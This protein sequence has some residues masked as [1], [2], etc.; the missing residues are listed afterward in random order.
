[1][2]RISPVLCLGLRDLKDYVRAIKYGETLFV[3]PPYDNKIKWKESD[4]NDEVI[5]YREDNRI[6]N[7]NDNQK[8]VIVVDKARTIDTSYQCW[9]MYF[10]SITISNDDFFSNLRRLFDKKYDYTKVVDDMKIGNVKIENQENYLT[11]RIMIISIIIIVFI[12]GY[13]LGNSN[14]NRENR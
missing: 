1:M 10:T 4:V 7:Q 14:K 9:P 8:D 5:I 11:N 12:A 6:Y 13:F 2:S 3:F